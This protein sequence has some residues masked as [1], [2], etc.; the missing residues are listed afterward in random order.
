MLKRLMRAGLKSIGVQVIR[1]PRKFH[2]KLVY[3][4]DALFHRLR[5][6]GFERTGTEQSGS[7]SV[8]KLYNTTQCFKATRAMSGCVA[9][10]GCFKGLSAFVFCSYQREVDPNFDG[11]G[12]H[13]FD[14]FEG[15]SEPT[16]EDLIRDPSVGLVG[17]SSLGQGSYAG[18]LDEV[19]RTLADF[20]AVTYHRGWLPESL[21]TQPERTY[22]FVHIDVDLYA[23]TLGAIQYFY[24]R[25]TPNGIIV[26]DDY[27]H[28]YW[29]GAKQAID[30]YCVPR[31]IPLFALTTGQ[32][33]IIRS[34]GPE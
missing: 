10:C 4:D 27:G 22:R 2:K 17:A 26:C 9:E 7:R 1:T 33:V 25:M 21:I 14:S 32:S 8:Q 15:L 5:A 3:E 28:L 24:P 16:R 23:P 18:T 13:I 34:L 12:F 31:A 19:K 11:K 6:T 29:P 30:E 20:P